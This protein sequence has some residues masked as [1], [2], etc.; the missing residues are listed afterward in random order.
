MKNRI[1]IVKH[2]TYDLTYTGLEAEIQAAFQL[3]LGDLP[4]FGA[5][6]T[7]SS[8]TSARRTPLQVWGSSRLRSK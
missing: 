4:R 8:S 3:A 2:D 1:L 6:M 7:W 5:S